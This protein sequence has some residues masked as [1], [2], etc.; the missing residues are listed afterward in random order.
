MSVKDTLIK[1]KEI[2]LK[3]G[4]ARE[5][6]IDAGGSVCALG[7]IGLAVGVAEDALDF[8]LFWPEEY[9]PLDIFPLRGVGKPAMDVLSKVI[10]PDADPDFSWVYQ[11]SDD[12]NGV[13][14]VAAK[15]DEAIASL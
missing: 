5:T 13:N 12:A 15:F 9:D 6:L 7:A 4:L 8:S 2:L 14:E 3:R 10:Q 11:F 1:A